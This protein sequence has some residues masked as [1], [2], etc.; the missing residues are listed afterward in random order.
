MTNTP[1]TPNTPPLTAADQRIAARID[2]AAAYGA[3]EL[4]AAFAAELA[5]AFAAAADYPVS[6]A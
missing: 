1:N 3:A 2:D 5:A 6:A 4:D